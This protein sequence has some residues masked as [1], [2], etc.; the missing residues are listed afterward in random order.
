MRKSRVALL[1]TITLLAIAVT[2]A[3]FFA[4]NW[5]RQPLPL[6]RSPFDFDVRAGTP[7]TTV[8][9]TLRDAG[10]I[11]HPYALTLLARAKGVDRAIKAGSYELQSGIT[12]PGLLAKLTQGDVTQTAVTIVE[13][14]TFAEV[15]RALRATPDVGHDIADLPD[16]ELLKRLG[17][18]ET[19]GEGI[20]F[21]DT[22]FLAT[23]SSDLALLRRAYRALHARLDAAW[24]LRAPDLPFATPYEAL[25][26]ASIVEKETAHPNDRPL[27]AS[28][29]IN[30]LKRGMRLQ[31]DPTVIYGM[32]ARFDGNLRKRDLETDTP[33]NTYVRDG[34]PP[35]PIALPSQASIDVVMNPP[36][37]AYL[38]F[39]SRGDGTSEF[40]ANLADHNRA[41]SKYQKGG[42]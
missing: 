17:A 5:Y 10:V 29:F 4:V 28:V 42:R 3:A 19:S 15:R 32:G 12:L 1:S 36:Q 30:R 24:V 16:A 33:Y 14:T 11:P 41:V 9:R 31:T 34:L 21:P 22:Y 39:V 26:L 6:P 27:I 8:A 25:I 13:G 40:S 18:T 35:T 2:L 38:Y 7:L 37:T 20:L 23:G